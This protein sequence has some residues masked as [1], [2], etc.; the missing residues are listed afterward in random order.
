M[1][2]TGQAGCTLGTAG[3]SGHLALLCSKHRLLPGSALKTRKLAREQL[4]SPDQPSLLGRMAS[5]RLALPMT[6]DRAR[7]WSQRLKLNPGCSFQCLQEPHFPH[8]QNGAITESS[9]SLPAH[10]CWY[11]PAT[12]TSPSVQ[13]KPSKPSASPATA[14]SAHSFSILGED[15]P[16]ASA[17]QDKHLRII[18]APS[19]SP[20]STLWK[21][22]WIYFRVYSVSVHLSQPLLSPFT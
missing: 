22:Y 10:R 11:P 1:A 3:A 16:F 20:C 21:A 13:L 15:D 6:A 2:A 19:L 14:S 9:A 8:L 18:V 4:G 12:P 7:L 5:S 17:A